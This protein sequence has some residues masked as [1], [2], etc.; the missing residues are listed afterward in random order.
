MLKKTILIFILSLSYSASAYAY[1]A[2]A[3]DTNHGQQYGFS[4]NHSTQHSASNRALNECGGNCQII[5]R[6]SNQCAAYAAD[7][8]F[9]STV[10]GWATASSASAAKSNALQHCKRHGGQECIIRVWGCE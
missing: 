2:L 1:G 7:Q 3:L 4:Y 5:Q 10:Y 8:T 6:F 9:N